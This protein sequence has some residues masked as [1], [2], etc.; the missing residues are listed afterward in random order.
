MNKRAKSQFVW[1]GAL[2]A[3]LSVAAPTMAA[4]V[5]L[6]TNGGFE[7]GF[8]GFTTDFGN[9][10]PNRPNRV[11]EAAVITNGAAFG[12]VQFAGDSFLAVNGGNDPNTDP[13]LWSQDVSVVAGTTYDFSVHVG[14]ATA[15]APLGN[16]SVRFD[17]LEILE[18]LAPAVD[19]TYAQYST[20]FQAR[21]TGNF[22][23]SFIELSTAFGSN[24][25]GLDEISLTFDDSVTPAPVPLPAAGWMLLAA[26]GGVTAM[27]RR[28]KG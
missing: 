1:A 20:S 19:N 2:F 28:K 10:T 22:A 3:C 17:G 27:K 18:I 13:L 12:L 21:S 23:L 14:T 7:N 9:T 6:V 5:E 24:D 11:L 26:I 15:S 8:T 4:T 25:Y 16:L